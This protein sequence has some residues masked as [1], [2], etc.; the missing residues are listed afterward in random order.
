[1]TNIFESLKDFISPLIDNE[2]NPLHVGE[3]SNL[4]ILLTMLEDGI[5][6]YQTSLNTSKD[7]EL[8]HTLE[9]GMQLSI[10]SINKLKTFMQHEGI[11]LTK[12]AEPKPK[13][14][15]DSIP[16]GVKQTDDEIANLVSVKV[17]AEI[18]LIG[19][20]LAMTIRND[21]GLIL[22]GT[23]IELLK[24]GTSLKSMMI[25]RGWIKVPPYYYPPGGTS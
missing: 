15:P 7:G 24:F 21:V 6:L 16:L 3:V 22:L 25:K 1:M 13:S 17:A 23:L 18:T 14:N 10:N 5:S 12:P 11:P 8:L 19:Q 9:K 20:A 4:W 2:K